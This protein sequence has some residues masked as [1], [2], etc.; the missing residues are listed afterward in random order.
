M[1]GYISIHKKIL[2]H[3]ICNSKHTFS[4]FEAWMDILLNV[5]G[6]KGKPMKIDGAFFTAERGQAL[7]SLETWAKRWRWDKSKVRR[8]LDKLQSDKMIVINNEKK[9]TRITVCNY[10]SYNGKKNAVDT[11]STPSYNILSND[12]IIKERREA[13][14]LSLGEYLPTYG[15]EMLNDFY[16]HWAEFNPLKT[17][18]KY[19]TEKTWELNLRL[20][21]WKS[22]AMKFNPKQQRTFSEAPPLTSDN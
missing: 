3:W 9:T 18:M 22:N 10:D 2:D 12:S 4:N 6:E 20:A 14:K 5:N 1:N 7:F 8:F 19:E 13:F 17:K 11:R 16:R 15:K 21:K